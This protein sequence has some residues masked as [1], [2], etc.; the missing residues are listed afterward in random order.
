MKRNAMLAIF[1]FWY[2]ALY[3]VTTHSPVTDVIKAQVRNYEQAQEA[4][5]NGEPGSAKRVVASLEECKDSL[6]ALDKAVLSKDQKIA[7]LENSLRKC[8]DKVANYAQGAGF[9][10]GVK[11]LA[12]IVIAFLILVFVIYLVVTGKLK[13]PFITGL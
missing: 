1:F 7:E 4:F 9:Q 3:C 11:W 6:I 8:G 12:G 10:S 2:A 5:Q 13:I